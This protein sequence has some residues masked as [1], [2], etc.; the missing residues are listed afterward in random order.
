MVKT[1]EALE[2][3]GK[4]VTAGSGRMIIIRGWP[5]CCWRLK[6]DVY[7]AAVKELQLKAWNM[8]EEQF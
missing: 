7:C 4:C 1:T 2:I 6:A 5:C 3:Y 8:E